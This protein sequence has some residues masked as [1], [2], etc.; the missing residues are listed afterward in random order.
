MP[1]RSL[2]GRVWVAIVGILGAGPPA[3]AASLQIDGRAADWAE[4]RP[5]ARAAE[6]KAAAGKGVPG[7]DSASA[8]VQDGRFFV[9]L[10]AS[11]AE[12]YGVL[13]DTDNDAA[14]GCVVTV[15]KGGSAV[16]VAG[17]EAALG[18]TLQG[19]KDPRAALLH[20]E[21]CNARAGKL[22]PAAAP[23]GVGRS[24]VPDG[25]TSGGIELAVPL[26]ALLG[27][28]AAS[29]VRMAFFAT[30]RSGSA[31]LQSVDGSPAAEPIRLSLR[32]AT[33]SLTATKQDAL[34]VDGNN[35]GQANPGDTLR[36][37]VTI[38]NTGS[39]GLD[40][41]Q[42]SDAPD[43]NTTLVPGSIHSTPLAYGQAA[44]TNEDTFVDI[45]LTG[46]DA[47]GDPLTFSIVTPPAIG[48][49]SNLTQVP[50]ASATVRYTPNS[51]ANGADS[52]VFRVTDLENNTND[53]TVAITVN[54]INDA[55]VVDLDPDNS[56]GNSPDFVRG[57]TEG[58]GPVAIGDTDLSASDVDSASLASATV[59]LTSNPDDAAESLSAN[60]AGTSITATYTMAT[61]VLS[62][63]GVDSVANY[64]QVLRSVVYDNTS[65]NPTTTARTISVVASDGTDSSTVVHSTIQFTAVNNAPVLT[66]GG[67]SPSFTEDGGP[68]A[69]DPAI[70]ASDVDSPNLLS[71]TVT[72][73]SRP[74][75]N[76]AESLAATTAGTGIT[77]TYTQATGVL[78]LTGTDS[79]ANYQQV[80]QSVTYNDTSQ[81]PSTTNRSIGFVVNDGSLD[82]NTVT[83]TLSVTAVND[84]P[85]LTAGGTLNYTENDPATAIDT[86]VTATDVD[87]TNLASATVQITGNYQ[88]GQD[89][90]SFT[91]T[92]NITGAFTAASGT[93]TLTG[94]DTVANYQAALRAVRYNN[95]SENPS[96]AARTVTWI[97]NDGSVSSSSV[98]S[99]INV[100]AVNDAPV[101]TAGGTLNYTENDPAPAIDTTVTATDVDSANLASATVQITG[102]YQNG[103]D[104]LSFTNTVNITG[105]FTAA[106]GTMTLTGADTVANY[107]AALRAVRYNNTSENP[108]AAV[109]TVT[110][111]GSDGSASSTPVT[112]TINVTPVNDPPVLTTN[113]ISYSTAGNTQ[114]HV[115]GATLPGVASIADASGALTKSTPTDVDGPG[116]LQ[117]VAIVNGPTSNG[118]VV[119]LNT[120]GSFTY[121]PPIGFSG[122]DSFTYQVTDQATPTPG[123]VTG[124]VNITVGTVVWYVRDVV[125]ASNP[126][127][128]DNDG[129]STNAFETLTDAQTFSNANSIIFVFLGNTA[130]TPLGG[131]IALKNGQRL[132]GEGIGLTVAPFGTLVPAGSQ[133]H[134]T[135]TAAGGNGV[136]ILANTGNGD[137]TGVEVRGLD[138]S[139]NTNAIDATSANTNNLGL[140]I[141]DN[142]ISGAGLD[143]ID[144]NPDANTP[145]AATLSIHNNTITATGTGL[146][147][148]DGGTGTLTVTA[149]ND[150]LVSGNT[151]GSGIVVA[152]PVTFDSTPGGALDPVAGGTTLIG[153][154][155]NGVGG[156]GLVMSGVTGDL[157]FDDLDIVAD[158][159]A[160]LSFGGTGT[161]TGAAGARLTVLPAGSGSST[162]VA[163]G[164]PAV[165]VSN[166][167][168]DLQPVSLTSTNSATT[169]V[170]LVNVADKTT[171]PPFS[172]IFSAPA[173]SN[174]QNPTGTAFNVDGG[175]AAITYAGAIT[176][177]AGRSVSV[178]NR[179]ADTVSFTGAINGTGMGVFLNGN[180]GS[181]ISFSGALTLS[182]GANAAFTATGG[183]TVTVT[184]STNTITATT[185]TAL[186]VA[187][188]TIGASG[189]TF[190]SVSAGTA[191]SGP[192]SGIILNSTGSSGGLTVLGTGSAASGGTI[193]Q[194]T[195]HGIS[196]TSTQSPSFANISVKNTSGSGIKGSFVTN[197]SLT[198][199]AIDNSGTGGVV[200]ESNV[201]FN[202]PPTSTAN[203][204]GT[205]TITGNSLTNS[206]Y[207]GVDL[208][209]FDGTI[210][211]LNVS[212]NTL[213]SS[214]SSASS[215][216]SAI[217]IT[218]R[219]TASIAANINGA[220]I[221]NNTITNF[222]SG[223]GILVQGGN[224]TSTSAPGVTLGTGATPITITGN[225]IAGPP[226][227]NMATQAINLAIDGVGSTNFNISNNGTVAQPLTNTQG[228]TIAAGSFGRTTA[229]GTISNNVVV[230]N[231]NVNGQPGIAAGVDQHFGVTDNPSMT[232]TVTNN[233]I[234]ATQGNGI[235]LTAKQ[236][237][238]ILA[239]KVQNNAVA[240][241]LG[242]VRPGIRIESG[243][244]TAGEN[245]TVCVNLR[246]NTSAGSSGTNGIGLRKQ[247]TSTSTDLFQ[248]H[249]LDV[250]TGSP[251]C[252]GTAVPAGTPNVEN[253]VNCENPAGNGTLLIS[254][255]SGFTAC[256]LP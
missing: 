92:A 191:A 70:A 252:S 211:S 4:V 204:T 126:G 167:T 225:L 39:A 166:A 193:Q 203:L 152:G 195:S 186:N 177:S 248:I 36:Y 197:F 151:G 55:P 188:T 128:P 48:A 3:L 21:R 173:S 22:E 181:T 114:L 87:N 137:R 9:E 198:N 200:D 32:T 170:S 123:T 192:A 226:V 78:S 132:W 175:N 125:D 129:R 124:T 160:A 45:T 136:T 43:A 116:P 35:D 146:S 159:G 5:L 100:T 2:A 217:R 155:G 255:T 163:T 84:A 138:I 93:M 183:G 51:N 52:F 95:T 161:F 96:A 26:E 107:Q 150:N 54:P 34:A 189:L 8:A 16:R 196:L 215:L 199:S 210:T 105:A 7:L 117:A 162:F 30:G 60:T 99:T 13:L 49:L 110:W 27:G 157:N 71:A 41:V 205:V 112:S 91:N 246:D 118:G 233:T 25:S 240:A 178:T 187:N 97:A 86:T 207:H 106:S 88:N 18:A 254:A 130:S 220:T 56:G 33:G 1:V 224:G 171:A 121:V 98:T 89:V 144:V 214:T 253:F 101:L 79:V 66:A 14:T 102:N 140:T 11:G 165:S 209:Q 231:S 218:V 190:R 251:A 58:G 77:A 73:T 94:A 72:L 57:F 221:N 109:R 247:G 143:G 85:V 236:S 81:N 242:G 53:D 223:A 238:G 61:G 244:N 237:N 37:T 111:I 213:T 67:G 234:S 63:T 68:V 24:L 250:G 50:P 113:P 17:I 119:N 75:G 82:S 142:T 131:G 139:G 256:S 156:A 31:V 19:G 174:I 76:A 158:N 120:D 29:D 38:T 176:N 64:Q 154:S 147:I 194:T 235:L 227:T 80:L 46:A 69:V 216:G 47:D 208:Q 219:G 62:L 83:K 182:T 229:T 245:T 28:S 228:V 206:R 164:G 103:Q 145:G 104:V 135:N 212:S 202:N 153:A 230:S 149:F 201:A 42:L 59:T 12:R 141:S 169:G 133:P 127:T 23:G 239:A 184:G 249:A 179:T 44:A 232:V 15:G 115:A 40:G 222:P 10:V 243:N 108:S 168:I 185:G 6:G 241:P 148:T 65:Q 180:T 20:L 172:A 90:L 134:I 74:D 122:T